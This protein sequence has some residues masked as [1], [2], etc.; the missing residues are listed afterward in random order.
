[1]LFVRRRDAIRIISIISQKR[2]KRNS[3]MR[4]VFQYHVPFGNCL[5]EFYRR[6]CRIRTFAIVLSDIVSS[7]KLYC[8]RTHSV[9]KERTPQLRCSSTCY[10]S[11]DCAI[12]SS[13]WRGVTTNGFSGKCFQIPGHQIS[14]IH[15]DDHLSMADTVNLPYIIPCMI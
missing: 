8:P 14:I 12:N 7:T 5:I 3:R 2:T 10:S 13:I 9:G 15:T 4:Q 1:M 11:A 6:K